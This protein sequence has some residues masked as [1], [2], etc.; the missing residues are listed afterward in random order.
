MTWPRPYILFYTVKALTLKS[1]SPVVAKKQ[2]LIEGKFVGQKIIS[3]PS[4][5]KK[6]QKDPRKP[7]GSLPACLY[8][9]HANRP[10]TK[11][12]NPTL[13]ATEIVSVCFHL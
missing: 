2:D 9:I 13:N 1:W 6:S 7:K 8:Y 5:R 11:E 4:K 12:E 3:S 10:I